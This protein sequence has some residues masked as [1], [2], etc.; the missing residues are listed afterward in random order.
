VK[1]QLQEIGDK[2]FNVIQTIRS[3]SRQPRSCHTLFLRFFQEKRYEMS[4]KKTESLIEYTN[5]VS[6]FLTIVAYK[7]NISWESQPHARTIL[8][9]MSNYVAK[10]VLI[11]AL[12]VAAFG[13]AVA[14]IRLVRFLAARPKYK[15]SW[16]RFRKSLKEPYEPE[17]WL[18]IAY[19]C[20]G[21]LFFPAPFSCLLVGMFLASLYATS[22]RFLF[23]KTALQSALGLGK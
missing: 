4:T 2:T 12:S 22:V 1:F 9:N 15:D 16:A 19:G 13:A 18:N 10:G 8:W 3:F 21:F 11:T 23:T 5:L 17:P 20:L 6:F 14:V 7:E